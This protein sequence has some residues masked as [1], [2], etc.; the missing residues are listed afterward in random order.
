MSDLMKFDFMSVKPHD[1]HPMFCFNM[2]TDMRSLLQQLQEFNFLQRLPSEGRSCCNKNL[3]L[4]GTLKQTV[5]GTTRGFTNIKSNHVSI[6]L[7]MLSSTYI[8]VQSVKMNIFHRSIRIWAL[9][10][11][12]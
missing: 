7:E 12:R 8:S 1:V 5:G 6:P 2:Q 4:S 11:T 9:Y 3:V 10:F